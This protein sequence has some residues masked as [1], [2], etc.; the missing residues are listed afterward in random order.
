M[1]VTWESQQHDTGAITNRDVMKEGQGRTLH[2]LAKREQPRNGSADV[3]DASKHR[4][5]GWRVIR[6]VAQAQYM[7]PPLAQQLVHKRAIRQLVHG[8]L[9]VHHLPPSIKRHIEVNL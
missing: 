9:R 1:H 5:V 6:T 2:T 8:V 3:S 4:G 7:G